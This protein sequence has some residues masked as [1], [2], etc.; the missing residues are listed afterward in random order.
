MPQASTSEPEE[1]ENVGAHLF[2]SSSNYSSLKDKQG[3][4]D[5]FTKVG[6]YQVCR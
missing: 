1:T 5:F 2:I 4:E 6:L 3:K